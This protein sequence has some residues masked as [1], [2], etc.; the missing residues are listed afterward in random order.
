QPAATTTSAPL[1]KAAYVTQMKRIGRSL[2]TSLNTLSSA[3]TAPKAATALTQVQKD[4]NG[5]ADKI[6]SIT[7]PAAVK[8]EHAQLGKAVRDSADELTPIIQKLKKGSMAALSTVPTL[9]GLQEI[10]TYSTAIAN[11]GYKI[12]G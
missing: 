5:A 10:Q 3:T 6:E 9:K 8:T 1:A 11:K 2:S 7:P 4:L 12:G